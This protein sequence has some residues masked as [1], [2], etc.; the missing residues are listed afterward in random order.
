[1]KNLI[2]ALLPFLFVSTQSFAADKECNPTVEAQVHLTKET[3]EDG[4]F[5][6][7]KVA[8]KSG[9][10]KNVKVDFSTPRTFGSLSHGEVETD[11]TGVA[12]LAFPDDLP[13]DAKGEFT[14]MAKVVKSE[15]YFG[16]AT[17]KVDGGKAIKPVDNP[18][19]REIWSTNTDWHLLLTIPVLIC[20]VWSVYIFSIRQLIKLSKMK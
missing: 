11:D 3:T 9:P 13:G 14:V 4:K 2:I 8:S 1:M 18:F 17:A 5:L 12:K 20:C 7:A 10:V 6:I 15:T 16:Q 19:P